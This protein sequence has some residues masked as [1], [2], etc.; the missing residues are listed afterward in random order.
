LSRRI[1]LLGST[2]FIGGRLKRDLAGRHE[3]LCERVELRDDR[4][5]RDAV[6]RLK[7]E[8]VVNAAAWAGPDACEKDP[9]T[10]RRVNALGPETL[11]KACAAAGIPLFHFSTDLVFDGTRP[12]YREEDKV[13]PL[14]AYGR[15]K[16]EAEERVLAAHPGACVVRV[17]M[18]YGRAL[19]G[20]PSPLDALIKDL[21]AGRAT[22]V[23]VDQWRTPTPVASL[24]QVIEGW[25]TKD[26]RGVYHWAGAERVSRV[27][28]ARH[29]CRR[30][31]FDP[32]LLVPIRAS[33]LPLPAPR[34]ADCSL[35]CSKLSG[36]L[37]LTPWTLERGLAAEG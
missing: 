15:V 33:E 24:V 35:D 26:L 31:G 9:E 2:G 25:L 6:S 29:V 20:R 18:V 3:L 23:F 14:S 36:A 11:A 12:P 16:R 19:G 4:A 27:E 8:A 28:F 13:N 22:K 21:S 1:L 10:A 32:G 30:F 17:A 7:P 5:I 34:P 37:G